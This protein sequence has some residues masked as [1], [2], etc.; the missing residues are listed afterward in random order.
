M[1]ARRGKGG[2]LVPLQ[3]ASSV[4]FW[5]KTPS[6]LRMSMSNRYFKNPS[7]PRAARRE[8]VA[9]LRLTSQDGCLYAAIGNL[10]LTGSRKTARFRIN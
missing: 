3:K 7:R 10:I 5:H 1:G 8:H 9:L 6:L 2:A 4:P